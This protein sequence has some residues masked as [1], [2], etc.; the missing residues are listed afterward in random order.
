[1]TD[2]K[3]APDSASDTGGA[4][5]ESEPGIGGDPTSSPPGGGL[6]PA[7]LGSMGTPRRLTEKDFQVHVRELFPIMDDFLRAIEAARA[8]RNFDAVI[9][10]V[11]LIHRGYLRLLETKGIE[12]ID[13]TGVPFNPDL[14]DVI[15]DVR[16]SD[17]EPPFVDS[18]RRSG[19]KLGSYVIR[20]AS[21]V[22]GHG[23]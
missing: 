2:S 21:V 12:P 19:F 9:E 10:G 20:K 16:T 18:V 17:A 3:P 1:M 14:H 4:S 5:S 22:I 6:L 7:P 23:N 15:D 11:S 8:G 13:A